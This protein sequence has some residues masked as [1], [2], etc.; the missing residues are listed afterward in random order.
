MK[1]HTQNMQENENLQAERIR[2]CRQTR[3]TY[4]LAK[5]PIGLLVC[6]GKGPIGPLG[7]IGK[8]PIGPLGLRQKDLVGVGWDR[9]KD[10]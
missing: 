9:H 8:G 10:L 4:V 7:S 1:K 6:T 2:L 5:G 3:R